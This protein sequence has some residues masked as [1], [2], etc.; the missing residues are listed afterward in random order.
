MQLL[1][2]AALF[3]PACCL[4]SDDTVRVAPLVWEASP[5]GSLQFEAPTVVGASTEHHYWFPA[6]AAQF[7]NGSAIVL[8][9]SYVDDGCTAVPTSNISCPHKP[10]QPG[11]ELLLSVDG[12]RTFVHQLDYE[13]NVSA[14]C[15]GCEGQ[16]F[17][18]C[19]GVPEGGSY[20]CWDRQSPSDSAT[21]HDNTTLTLTTRRFWV[22]P[23]GTLQ[24]SPI[25]GRTMTFQ[26]LPADLARTGGVH[27]FFQGACMAAG[28]DGALYM[29]GGFT[30]PGRH[31][32]PWSRHPGGSWHNNA[33]TALFRSTDGAH[34]FTL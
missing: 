30:M 11:G 3:L 27:G 24:S 12:G 25:T 20:V 1:L 6:Y 5:Q 4:K 17:C 9:H 29:Y 34:T 22:G 10:P 26:G 18:G 7:N 31:Q 33:E 23:N 21:K 16:H 32:N 28:A 15:D 19:A 14:G 2:L 8:D 13:N